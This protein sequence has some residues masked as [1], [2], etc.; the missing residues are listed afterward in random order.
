MICLKCKKT[1]NKNLLNKKE[2]EVLS[3]MRN[4]GTFVCIDCINLYGISKEELIRTAISMSNSAVLR[5]NKVKIN[6]E[7]NSLE[8][9]DEE[10][11][12]FTLYL[13]TT[14]R[15]YVNYTVLKNIFNKL[16]KLPLRE[17]DNYVN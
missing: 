2:T 7:L 15:N 3:D 16:S 9:L 11:L 14:Y 6:I 13:G 5:R 17:D 12:I 1:K 10:G 8:L 4:E